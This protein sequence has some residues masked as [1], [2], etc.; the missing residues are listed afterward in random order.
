MDR[1]ALRVAGVLAAAAAAC[2]AAP[3]DAQT[4]ATLHVRSFTMS[5]D[6]ASLRVGE[7]FRLAIATHVDER[8]LELDNVTLPDLSGFDVRGDERRCTESARGSDCIETL[9]VVPTVAGERTIAAA[10]MDAV[11]GRNGKPSRFAS[12]TLALHVAAAPARLPGWFGDV[13]WAVVLAAL[14]LVSAAFVIYVLFRNFGRP[15]AVVRAQPVPAPVAVA[16]VDPDARLRALVAALA[17]EPSRER[18]LAVRAA[19]RE[20]VGARPDETLADI[21]RRSRANAQPRLLAALAAVERASFCEAWNVARAVEEA[22]PSLN[23]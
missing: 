6:P 7:S 3:C 5:A 13:L 10:V 8:I 11:D 12:N 20:R 1:L 17:A 14:P 4:L 16:A 23:F 9:N 2:V 19:W 18:A 15:R 21:A 22:L